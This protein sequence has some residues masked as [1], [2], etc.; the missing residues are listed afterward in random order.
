MREHPD[1]PVLLQTLLS[2]DGD[3]AF[4]PDSPSA[5]AALER[6][7]AEPPLALQRRRLRP[8]RRV[9]IAG[10]LALLAAAAL[11]VAPSL[12]GSRTATA[13]AAVLTRAAAALE[14]SDT[15]L[16]LQVQTYSA[17]GA[18]PCIEQAAAPFI[19]CDNG[20]AADAQTGISANPADD[21]LTGSYQV[22]L[23][24]DRS[25]VHTVYS[26]GYETLTDSAAQ[27]YVSYSPAN[28]T[29]TT[30]TDAGSAATTP[31]SAPPPAP[32][33]LPSASELGNPSYYEQLYREAQAGA[34][35][36]SGQTTITAQL[37]GQTTLAGESV[38]ALRFNVHF[39]PLAN[40]PAG[41]ICGAA[42][43]TPPDREILLY[44]DSQTFMPVRSVTV[45]D[46]TRDVPGIAPGSAVYV[47]ALP[48]TTANESRLQMS[49]HAGATQDTETEQQ[50]R[51]ELQ[52]WLNAQ[53][54]G[55]AAK[56]N[57]ARRAAST[58][59]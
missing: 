24:P 16:H 35:D 39:T 51:T 53:A 59:S 22:W 6:I 54:A 34:Q 19:A 47:T 42:A 13:Q 49:A 1:T 43:C 40:P 30:L 7:L 45:L 29:L 56:A 44:L 46:N 58:R 33:G 20:S 52:T 10:A 15:I 21:T 31:G 9:A 14:Q 27:D 28:D 38:D 37:L 5:R 23:S 57:T 32:L 50:F 4:D 25:T 11:A 41:D 2:H 17:T 12:R 36:S 26:D 55:Q 8:S 18:G 48:D 3:D